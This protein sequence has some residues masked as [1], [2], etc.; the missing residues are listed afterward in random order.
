M[1]FLVGFGLSST[2]FILL[3][4]VFQP[5]QEGLE[6]G[7]ELCKTDL[8]KCEQIYEKMQLE[9]KLGELRKQLDE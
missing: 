7:V 8:P 2:L 1:E 6:Q 3:L 9:A 5:Y 4:N